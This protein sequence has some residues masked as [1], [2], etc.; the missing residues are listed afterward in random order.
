MK[1]EDN[2]TLA[3]LIGKLC[4][5]E[6]DESEAGLLN[7]LLHRN[8]AAREAYLDH[9]ALHG[10]LERQFGASATNFKEPGSHAGSSVPSVKYR[11]RGI[12]Q[13]AAGIAIGA[14]LTS[15]VWAYGLPLISAV[16]RRNLPLANSSFEAPIA[17][18]GQG[19]PVKFGEWSGD[20]VRITGS[21]NGIR[22]RSGKYMLSFLRSDDAATPLDAHTVASELWQTVNLRPLRP[23]LGNKS[24]S[25]RLSGFF[26]AVSQPGHRY[27]AGVSLAAYYGNAADAP[28]LW[29][30]RHQQ[31]LAESEKEERLD[32]NPATWQILETQL[33]VPPDA[34]LLMVQIRV[35]DKSA[36]PDSKA[37]IFPGH[38]ADNITLQ[39]VE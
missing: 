22:P 25:V 21:E 3:R 26:N 7:E 15:A 8:P 18:A 36:A 4:A 11:F 35:S 27:T 28:E 38:Y 34:E 37:A 1:P 5:S 10:L 12:V 19:V 17:T 39:V 2:A 9:V 16:A 32:D 23:M 33:N 13:M 29:K 14:F 31:S 24:I 6:L 20:F 30:H